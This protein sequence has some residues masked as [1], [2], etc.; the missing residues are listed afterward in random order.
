MRAARDQ[1]VS[2]RGKEEGCGQQGIK[3]WMVEVRRDLSYSSYDPGVPL[4]GTTYPCCPEV[5]VQ[6]GEQVGG[7]GPLKLLHD[8]AA[9]R[10]GLGFVGGEGKSAE[11][12]L[13]GVRAGE[14]RAARKPRAP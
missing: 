1:K 7:G 13:G 12:A 8:A 9:A 2:G 11:G 4:Y 3:R 6:G 5:V 14:R 10:P